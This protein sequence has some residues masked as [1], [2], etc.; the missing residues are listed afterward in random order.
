MRIKSPKRGLTRL[1]R[2][3]RGL[4]PFSM[5]P[6]LNFCG[7]CDCDACGG[8]TPTDLL[9]DCEFCPNGTAS[10]WYV[11]TSGF[12]GL[13]SAL[14]GTF[15]LERSDSDCNFEAV[16]E[17][18]FNGNPVKFF[19]E[20]STTNW[21]VQIGTIPDPLYLYQFVG[22]SGECCDAATLDFGTDYGAI[23]CTY[24]ASISIEPAVPCTPNV[25]CNDCCDNPIPTTL[26]AHLTFAQTVVTCMPFTIRYSIVVEMTYDS[27]N[28]WWNGSANGDCSLHPDGGSGGT[29]GGSSAFFVETWFRCFSNIS[30]AWEMRIQVN[31]IDAWSSGSPDAE[32]IGWTAAGCS[33]PSTEPYAQG[34]VVCNPFDTMTETGTTDNQIDLCGRI[35][36][37]SDSLS[38]LYRVKETS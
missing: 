7:C 13:C 22:V 35:Y 12:A 16:T 30:Q 29:S 27:G 19:L 10:S 14:N 18:T 38:I 2:K 17:M 24:P 20:R 8:G 23:S 33:P 9:C 28:S 21:N 26:Y 25:A 5:T 34:A 15:L 31:G 6:S 11:T 4:A 32:W 36:G 37:D 3:L 1:S